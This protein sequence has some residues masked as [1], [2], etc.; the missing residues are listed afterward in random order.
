[1][2]VLLTISQVIYSL[3]FIA[4]LIGNSLVLYVIYYF[5]PKKAS[6]TSTVSK[7]SLVLGCIKN[8]VVADLISTIGIPFLI[9]SLSKTGWPYGASFCKF[10]IASIAFPQFSKAFL[11]SVLGVI[12]YA[13]HNGSAYGMTDKRVIIMYIGSWLLAALIAIPI[14]A[15]AMVTSKGGCNVFWP[16]N[17]WASDAFVLIYAICVF[18][19]PLA[20]GYV[21]GKRRQE[22][23][24]PGE[25]I[26]VIRNTMS[27][28]F[29]LIGTH[30]VLLFP[31]LISQIILNY[32][33]TAPGYYPAWKINFSLISGWIWSSSCAIFPYVYYYLSEEIHDGV[34]FTI[35]N[36]GKLRI[37]YT[38]I[39]E[40]GL[41]RIQT[42][43]SQTV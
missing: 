8:L 19:L 28:V 23:P 9:S 35:E 12:C 7:S 5:I 36:I 21:L 34:Q 24:F 41:N 14:Y 29:G 17:I 32:V 30:L 42:K 33:R 37:N 38:M 16:E 20:V 1:M 18:I 4:S 6:A 3:I 31:H 43:P 22:N 27:M 10:Y 39:G 13:M 11:M 25:D 40:N 26:A 15:Y 2:S